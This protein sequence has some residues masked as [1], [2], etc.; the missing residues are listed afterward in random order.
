MQQLAIQDATETPN[1][2]EPKIRDWLTQ[3]ISVAFED[4][5]SRRGSH[6]SPYIS[7][8]EAIELAAI[9]ISLGADAGAV[10]A[11]RDDFCD[12][13]YIYGDARHLIWSI[14]HS[15]MRWMSEFFYGP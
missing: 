13:E 7:R 1:A 3:A 15:E 2:P 5:D 4:Q 9:A 6:Y 8:L 14:I 12:E 11:V 10:C